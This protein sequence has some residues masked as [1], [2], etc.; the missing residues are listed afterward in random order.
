MRHAV[1]MELYGYWNGLRAGRTAPE[2]N[3]VEPGAIRSV[4]ADTFV[5]EYDGG[6]GFPFR[7]SGSRIN[8]LF[9]RE[10]RGLSFLK[11][12]RETDRR[13]IES[14]LR[15]VADKAEPRLLG[16][17]ANS[18]GTGPL[19][20]EVALLPLCH[21]GSTHCR[22]LGSLAADPGPDLLGFVG[23][24]PATLISVKAFDPA[25]PPNVGAISRIA[26]SVRLFSLSRDRAP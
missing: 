11:L 16:A 10:L 15:R 1:A 7:I 22:V 12:W 6:T 9:Q 14:V 20:I 8:A 3:D 2:R 23:A 4:L 21:H 25:A 17:E 13:E 18:P 26:A 24:G 19:H 5:L